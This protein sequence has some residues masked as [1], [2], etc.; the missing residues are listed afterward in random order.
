MQNLTPCQNKAISEIEAFL[1]S[2]EPELIITGPAG[3]GKSTVVNKVANDLSSVSE[4]ATILGTSVVTD[5]F[6]T[7]TTNKAASII[8]G[9]TIDKF[10]GLR[11]QSNK[12]TGGTYRVSTNNS[13]E[14][15]NVLVSIDECGLTDPCLKSHIQKQLKNSKVI[16]VGDVAQLISIG[17]D[18]SPIFDSGIRTIEMNT[19]VRQ[20]AGSDLYAECLKLREAVLSG[21]TYIPSVN[22]QIR[23]INDDEAKNFMIHK[24]DNDRILTFTNMTA[25]NMNSHVRG[26]K[27]VSG[28]WCPGEK[29][30]SNGIVRSD[31]G[32]KLIL[33]NEQEFTI[34]EV[35]D[36]HQKEQFATYGVR[37][38]ERSSETIIVPV[39]S[40]EYFKA[41]KAAA[42][43]KNWPEMFR[44][45]EMVADLRGPHACTIHKSQ[46]SSY[47]T[48]MI[49]A[50]DLRKAAYDHNMFR[51][52]L[53]VAV[54]RA[55]NEVLIYGQL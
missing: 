11:T 24:Q 6:S 23:Y 46:G 43:S 41:I 13:R 48:V 4:L 29:V 54:S 44:L 42:S 5:Y 1:L 51:R 30:I 12:T 15:D 47:G 10:L 21:Q 7:A 25:V 31:N 49:H 9:V 27:G 17:L 18:H 39:N 16:Y 20:G 35:V 33:K 19:P 55:C 50:E 53:Y 36:I 28:N 40:E 3:V 37:T 32:G 38:N 52:L 8:D 2:D 45:K 34:S 26:F 22:S 14:I